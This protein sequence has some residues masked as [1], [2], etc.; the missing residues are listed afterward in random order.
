[1]SALLNSPARSGSYVFPD[2][3]SLVRA[4]ELAW[5]P[6]A[7]RNVGFKLLDVD[8]SFDKATFLLHAPGGATI[9]GFRLSGAMEIFIEA[10]SLRFERGSLVEGDYVY[11]PGGS[12]NGEL[13]LAPGTQLYVIAHGPGCPRDF[14]GA[15]QRRT[16][17]EHIGAR[18][19]GG[20]VQERAHAVAPIRLRVRA[21]AGRWACRPCCS[22]MP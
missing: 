20:A 8:R 4:R 5:T 13:V 10:G 18:A 22:A 12:R 15:H 11:L 9:P 6:W 14:A 19:G 2:G 1:M 17:G 3:S 21:D 16:V 7:V